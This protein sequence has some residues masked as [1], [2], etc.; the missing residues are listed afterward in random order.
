MK[1]IRHDT[2]IVDAELQERLIQARNSGG[3]VGAGMEVPGEAKQRNIEAL[4]TAN[5]RRVQES[6]RVM[7]ELARTPDLNLDTEKYRKL[8]FELYDLEKNLLSKM[9]RQDKL[10]RLTGLYVIIDTAMLKGRNYVEVT[11][12]I[13]RGGVKIIQL[14][15]KEHNKNELLA[16]ASEIRKICAEH[17]VLFIMNDHIDIALAIGVGGLHVGSDD[18]PVE[19][20]RRLLPIDKILGCSARSVDEAARAV[21]EG[22]DYIGVGAMYQTGTKEKAEVVG[23]G[24]L[25]EIRKAVDLPLVAI[26]GINKENVNRIIEAGADS[27]AV[28]SA[29]LGAEDIEKATRELVAII[30]GDRRE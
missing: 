9:L 30:G 12:Q 26:G 8:R 23:P 22:A 17:N 19:V 4:I 10:K 18:L 1:N 25:Q 24:R 14:R 20:A 2:V 3:D 27:V 21:A 5:S 6:L 28:I 11:K 29:V 16:I 13:I 15:D 7:E